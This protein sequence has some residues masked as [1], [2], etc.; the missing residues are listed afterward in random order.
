MAT[1]IIQVRDEDFSRE[2]L[3]ADV[4][5]LVDFTAAWCPPCR[6]IHPAVESLAAEYRGRVKV[7]QLTVDDNEAT[8]QAYG[9][10]ALPTLLFFKQ[11]QVVNQIVGAVPRAR[12]ASAFE[13]VL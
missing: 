10:R 9:V 3:D 7:T 8:A 1:D 11:G 4:P 2:V 13:Q 12:L 6:A 5:V